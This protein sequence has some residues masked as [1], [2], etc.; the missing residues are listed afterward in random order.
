METEHI[1][2]A[3]FNLA[4]NAEFAFNG[5]DLTTL[6]WHTPEITKPTNSQILAEAQRLKELLPV[7]PTITE[8][9]AIVGLTLEELKT[10]LA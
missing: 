8:K 6:E 2:K 10:A 3:I 7:A 4:P 1:F 5:D 9:L